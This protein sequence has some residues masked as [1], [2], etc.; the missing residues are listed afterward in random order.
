MSENIRVQAKQDA[1]KNARVS[2]RETHSTLQ[3]IQAELKTLVSGGDG[4]DGGGDLPLDEETRSALIRQMDDHL[5]FLDEKVEVLNQKVN[6]YSELDEIVGFQGLSRK[7]KVTKRNLKIASSDLK[8]SNENLTF[9]THAVDRAQ[10]E[11]NQEGYDAF[12]IKTNETIDYEQQ[13]LEELITARAGEDAIAQQEAVIV[14]FQGR[15]VAAEEAHDVLNENL[16][17]QMLTLES[18]QGA[19]GVE[20]EQ[21]EFF[22][23]KLDNEL[24]E[25]CEISDPRYLVSQLNDDTPVLLLPVRVETRYMT[26]KHVKRGSDLLVEEGVGPA[27]DVREEVVEGRGRAIPRDGIIEEPVR[28]PIEERVPVEE[29]APVEEGISIPD[30]KELWVRIFPDDLAVHSH[31]AR[32]TPDEELGGHSYWE[33]FWNPTI[34]LGSTINHKLGAWRALNGAYGPQRAAWIVKETTPTNLEVDHTSFSATFPVLIL[35][36]SAWTEAPKSYVLPDRFVVRLYS[37]ATSYRE[38]VGKM[39]PDP[40]TLGIAPN[41]DPDYDFE[42]L[43]GNIDFPDEIKWLSDFKEAENIG[44]GLSIP[45]L[46]SEDTHIERI[47]VLGLK[48]TADK[49]EATSLFE[50]LIENHHYTSGGF[51]LIPQGTPTNNTEGSKS[52]YNKIDTDAEITFETEVEDNL[53][54]ISGDLLEKTDGQWF[55]N[56]LGINPD[57]MQHVFNANGTDVCEALA[58]NR[59]LW[60]ATMGYYLKQ[61]M[62]PHVSSTDRTTTRNF[63]NEFVTGRGKIPTF[64]VD[65]QPYGIITGTVFSRWN[66]IGDTGSNV[67]YLNGLNNNM[68]KPMYHIWDSF[69]SDYVKHVDINNPSANPSDE[70]INILGLHAS[71]VEFHQRFAN[72]THKMWNMWR[73]LTE[74]ETSIPVG[75]PELNG[76]SI[77]NFLLAYNSHLTMTMTQPPKIFELNF[78][79]KQRLLN[80]PVIDGFKSLVYSEIRGIQPFPET[81]WNYIDWL[82][83]DSTTITRIREE[84]FDNLAGIEGDQKP[85]QALL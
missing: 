51:S 69:V 47:L 21:Y 59:A 15:L 75:F 23:N 82:L 53:F 26:V 41:N 38:V 68:L 17:T 54:D 83:D 70:F 12:V 39:I 62:H 1:I 10:V 46:G 50:E 78:L 25:F 40:L 52:G 48:L 80:G 24:L 43:E 18:A 11:L 85:P 56:M 63:F 58:M 37:D 30:R 22:F 65:D 66:Y 29:D 45:L 84:L 71:S 32:L 5:D 9:A 16:S 60:P 79:E 77:T 8:I 6:A 31:E 4:E 61:M 7:V 57:I 20:Q 2:V 27:E 44:M 55:A 72:G 81:A 76:T 34:V 74:S 28:E 3:A 33:A 67:E 19:V 64:R 36:P 35:K 73:F 13:V 49:V 14:D 42:Q